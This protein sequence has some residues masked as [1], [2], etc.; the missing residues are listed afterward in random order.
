MRAWFSVSFDSA[1]CAT[2]RDS[3]M[4]TRDSD[5]R[6]LDSDVR[7]RDSD[8]RA[9]DSDMRA[10]DS[11]MRARDS[12]MRALDSDMR[13]LDSDMTARDSDLSFATAARS[14]PLTR[15]PARLVHQARLAHIGAPG[16]P[17]P[18]AEDAER[19][20][21]RRPRGGAA[22]RPASDSGVPWYP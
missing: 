2:A 15:T 18:S 8:V 16:A 10:L 7:A 11:D 5:I 6:A 22:A 20:V 17:P 4:R 14:S 19:P 21:H 9:R 1:A 13:A 12:D 3:D